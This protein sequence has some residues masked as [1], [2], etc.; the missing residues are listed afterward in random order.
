MSTTPSYRNGL[1]RIATD[2]DHLL[3]ILDLRSRAITKPRF[4]PSTPSASCAF[5]T[6]RPL[7]QEFMTLGLCK[8]VSH[9]LSLAF[10]QAFNLLKQRYEAELQHADEACIKITLTRNTL[11]PNFQD[12]MRSIYV[13]KFL[14]TVKSWTSEGMVA[15][16]LRLLDVNLKSTPSWRMPIT[17]E[18][19]LPHSTSDV[20]VAC[21]PVK[22][23]DDGSSEKAEGDNRETNLNLSATGNEKLDCLHH[24]R[25]LVEL[26]HLFRPRPHS[27]E[28]EFETLFSRDVPANAFP[29]QY[30]CPAPN[31][32]NRCLTILSR[33][34]KRVMRHTLESNIDS[35]IE[36]M[37]RFTVAEC[38]G[39]MTNEDDDLS[40]IKDETDYNHL[41]P[42]L[43]TSSPHL[44]FNALPPPPTTPGSLQSRTH[45]IQI[46]NPNR[47]AAILPK[48]SQPLS[49]ACIPSPP[50][51][52]SPEASDSEGSLFSSSS[53]PVNSV[54]KPDR[55]SFSI[56]I[57]ST[58]LPSRSRRRK[59]MPL[60]T[61]RPL[62]SHP[63][64]SVVRPS[65]AA[66]SAS[67][68]LLS[69]ANVSALCQPIS[70]SARSRSVI[71]RTP[72]LVSLASSDSRSSSPDELN[73]PPSTPPAFVTKFPSSISS[74]SPI[75][76][77]KYEPGAS[78]SGVFQFSSTPLRK[79]LE[80]TSPSEPAP[81]FSF[82]TG[83][84]RE[85]R[86]F[87]FTFSRW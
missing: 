55:S 48:R 21:L 62:S 5:P 73:T 69:V 43:P 15:I 8:S 67:I 71:P 60:P 46:P 42:S 74:S 38:L 37:G 52:N 35:L 54:T 16:Q 58:P 27:D 83:I 22:N 34:F 6:P 11:A 28:V 44:S 68:A 7:T 64:A 61:R 75:F 51:I 19:C 12:R 17:F 40:K 76:M 82:S 2:S 29:K 65:T 36:T 25:V 18:K 45:C 63:I 47:R 57:P 77:S 81:L 59:V 1:Q 4:S 31:S 87:S 30:P 33:G 79:K 41:M 72:S 39:S 80:I 78:S 13:S 70:P 24:G 56:D 66:P 10:L 84:K 50:A 32:S 23:V 86:S 9:C 3:R 20:T 85:E 53:T 14:D 26:P 49:S